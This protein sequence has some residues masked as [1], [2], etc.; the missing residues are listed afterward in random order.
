MRELDACGIGFVADAHGRPARSI[1][2]AALE[3]LAN[4]KHRGAVAADA[5]TSDGCGVLL[6]LP[7]ALFGEGNGVATLFVKGPDPRAAVEAAL[8]EEGF[9]LVEWRRPPID[10]SHL[11]DLAR[12]SQPEI[13]HVVFR[14]ADDRASQRSS[15]DEIRA[16]RLRR[17]IAASPGVYVASCSFRTI[18]FKGLT[19]A[20]HL[21]DFYRDL[22]DERFEAPFTIFHQRFSTNT[23][24]TWERAQP[25]RMLCHNGEIN[26]IQGNENRMRARARLGTEGAGLGPE[27]LFRPVLDPDDSDSGKLDEAVELLTRGG[28]DIRHA[29]AML[30]PEAWENATDLD[31]EV[32]GFYRYHATLMEP[33]DGP[34]GIVF[35]DGIGV[36]ATLDRNGLRPLRYSVCEDGFVVCASEVG[37]VDVSGHGTVER[38]RLGPGQMLFIDPSRGV[39]RNRELKERLAAAAPYAHWAFEGLYDLPVGEPV[40]EPP[41]DLEFRQAVHGYTKEELA[42]VLRPMAG[43]AYE[44]TFSMGDDSPLPPLAGR[45]RPVHHFLRQRFAQVTNPAIDSLRERQV[46]ALDSFIGRRGNLLAESPEQA[47]LVHL[48]SIAIDDAC[49]AALRGLDQDGLRATTISTIFAI[50]GGGAAT[51]GA[52]LEAELRRVV[53][54]AAQAVHDGAGVIILS[55]RGIDAGHAAVPVLLA[56]GAVHHALI[57]AGLRSRADLVIESGEVCDVH[58]LATLIGYGASAVNPHVALAQAASLAG[59]R[60][61]EALTPPTL[62]ANYLHA[63]EKGFLKISSKMGISTAMGYRGAQIFETLGLAREI[64]DEHFTGTP[65]RL[66][67]IGYAE[68]E[69]DILRRHSEAY[70]DPAP[71]LLDQGFVRY[72]KEGEAHAFEPPLVKLLQEAVNTGS[73]EVYQAYRDHIAAHPA[74]A[75]RDLLTVQPLGAPAP[76]AEVEPVEAIIKRFVVTAMSLGSLSPEAHRTLSTAMNRLGARSN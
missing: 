52:L 24:P 40:Q 38:G 28:R 26:A 73:A 29:M 75:V 61:Y 31:P 21:G 37:A 76:L 12:A 16:Y 19:P 18:V 1:V 35:T 45:P 20:D 64:V 17:T 48:P 53:A 32:R 7:A 33:W 55:D 11:G 60:G 57:R 56:T 13:V 2:T 34:A 68:L 50:P 23:L 63:L 54:E 69:E 4:V 30:V 47:R 5:L 46:M 44:P 3:G 9:A 10:E 71:K 72:R 58:A 62:R 65:A 49:L 70:T 6:P 43:D 42:M 27:E 14:N 36:G 22:Q 25:F 51:G 74:T 67:G 8:A 39:Q 66:C 59:T 15:A 41:D